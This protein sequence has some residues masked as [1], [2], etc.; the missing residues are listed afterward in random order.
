M[1]SEGYD[2]VALTSPGKELD[3][4]KKK[5]FYG[6]SAIFWGDVKKYEENI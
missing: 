1:R 4:L 5:R 6:M 3:A 2:M